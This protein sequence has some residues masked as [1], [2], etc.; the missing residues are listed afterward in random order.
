[1]QFQMR[2]IVL[3]AYSSS[4]ERFTSAVYKVPSLNWS[5][6][7]RKISDRESNS[8]PWGPTAARRSANIKYLPWLRCYDGEVLFRRKTVFIA[9]TTAG[10]DLTTNSSSLLG[11]RR[12]RYH[13]V[14]QAR[15]NWTGYWCTLLV[16]WFPWQSF[17]FIFWLDWKFFSESV[18]FKKNSTE[19]LLINIC[20]IH[21]MCV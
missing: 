3:Y 1:M 9:T 17:L 11:G 6:A 16:L 4:S 19:I 13:Y 7:T 12:R 21:K 2:W 18:E 20:F 10:F 5:S 14:G 8:R 15:A